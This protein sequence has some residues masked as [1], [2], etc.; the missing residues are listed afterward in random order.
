MPNRP[1]LLKQSDLTRYVKAVQN[2]GVPVGRVVIGR[3]GT[4]TVYPAG[5]AEGA[6]DPNPWDMP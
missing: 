4:V 3:D 2:A 6:T 1:A 5:A